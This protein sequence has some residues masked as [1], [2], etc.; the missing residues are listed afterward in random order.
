MSP[1]SLSSHQSFNLLSVVNPNISG[2]SAV[3]PSEQLEDFKFLFIH[4]SISKCLIR[5]FS[6]IGSDVLLTVPAFL[7]SCW[8]SCSSLL[9]VQ[10]HVKTREGCCRERS[11]GRGAGCILCNAVGLCARWF[12]HENVVL[13]S[14]CRSRSSDM[15]CNR[16]DVEVIAY[17]PCSFIFS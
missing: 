8:I 4:T 11:R 9:W 13:T 14:P 12:L 6:V 16:G 3:R 5:P 7:R 2:R 15:F 10:V 1:C 17:L